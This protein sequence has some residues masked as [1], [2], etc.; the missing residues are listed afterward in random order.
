MKHW[1]RNLDGIGCVNSYHIS[2]VEKAMKEAEELKAQL[3][4][5]QKEIVEAENRLKELLRRN[6]SEDEILLAEYCEK[7]NK[8]AVYMWLQ[9]SPFLKGEIFSIFRQHYSDKY[10]SVANKHCKE[11]RFVEVIKTI[12]SDS[13]RH[14]YSIKFLFPRNTME[15]LQPL[16]I[17]F[18]N[19]DLIDTVALLEVEKEAEIP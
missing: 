18:F 14:V 4:R 13:A 3:E 11:C 10:W 16:Q 7:N 5:S 8:T 17:D 1:S 15:K 2:E 19:S 6:Y 9:K 12:C